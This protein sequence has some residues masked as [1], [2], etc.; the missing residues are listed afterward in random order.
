MTVFWVVLVCNAINLID[1]LDGLAAGAALFSMV[2]IFT[3]AVVQGRSGVAAATAILAGSVLGFLVFNFNPA[4]IFLG[5]SGSLFIGFI[6]SG[7][8]L[9]ESPKQQSPFEVIFIPLI[10]LA[11]PL[12]DTALSVTRRFLNGHR[13]FGADQEHIHH[14]LLELGL[15][16]RQVVW[17]LYAVSALGTLLGLLLLVRSDLGLIPVGAAFAM[18][19]FFGVRKLGYKEFTEFGRLWVRLRRQRRAMARNIGALKIIEE[20]K[21]AQTMGE[22]FGLLERCLSPDFDGFEIILD[23]RFDGIEPLQTCHGLPQRFWIPSLQ[24]KLLLD[25]ALVTPD[26]GVVGRL[27]LHHSVARELL[28]DTSLLKGELLSGIAEALERCFKPYLG[29]YPDIHRY[30]RPQLVQ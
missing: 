13:L 29:Q 15:T 25:L 1:G 19:V 27:L 28:L 8:V 17:I 6:L 12:M 16:H 11:L 20:L 22:I 10:S 24:Q 3:V 18:V 14:K 4:S 2:T 23:P 5:D 7:L 21:L 9:A 26:G 30:P